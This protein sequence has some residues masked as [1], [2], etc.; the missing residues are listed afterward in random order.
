MVTEVHLPKPAQKPHRRYKREQARISRHVLYPVTAFYTLYSVVLFYLA[1][2]SK[3][4]YV[5]IGFYAISLPV[6][7][8]LEYLAHRY[9]LHGTFRK[10]KHS[11]KVYKT[12]AN[13][14]FD[15]LHWE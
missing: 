9:I 12:L 2:R 6:W 5:A 7:T 15:P 11:W 4:P 8:Y 10:S 3:H 1:L 13:K 14:F